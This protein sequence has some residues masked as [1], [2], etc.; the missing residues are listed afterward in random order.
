M[1]CRAMAYLTTWAVMVATWTTGCGKRPLASHWHDGA[2]ALDGRDS[3]CSEGRVWLEDAGVGLGLM[4]D[5]AAR[6]PCGPAAW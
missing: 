5:A 6:A 3:E 2:I 4:N 1:S